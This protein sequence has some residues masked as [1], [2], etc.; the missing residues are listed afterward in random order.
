MQGTKPETQMIK[1]EKEK[2]VSS[3]YESVVCETLSQSLL[4]RAGVR[5]YMCVCMHAHVRAF[6]HVC[7]CREADRNRPIG[8]LENSIT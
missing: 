1:T 7:M 8:M 2:Q 3:P 5:S 6:F 4:T